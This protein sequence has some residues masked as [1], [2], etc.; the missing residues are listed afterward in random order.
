MGISS[1]FSR[2]KALRQKLPNSV[3]TFFIALFIGS[4]IAVLSF[5]ANYAPQNAPTHKMPKIEVRN[6]TAYEI[7]D[8]ALLTKLSAKVGK[9][10][11]LPNKTTS[12]ELSDIIVERNSD[13]FDTLR[14]KKARKVGENIYFDDGVKNV[15]DGYEIY[16]DIAVYDLQTRA[17]RGRDDFYIK[18]AFEDIKGENISYENGKIRAQNIHAT[19]KLRKAQ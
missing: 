19:I 12:E 10:F 5:N 18:S 11:E 2:I 3:T 16:S 9:Q 8:K 13:A 7:D 4:I 15:R 6:F 17:I 1:T 14:A